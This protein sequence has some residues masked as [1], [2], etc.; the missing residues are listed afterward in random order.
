MPENVEIALSYSE[1][2]DS[3]PGAMPERNPGTIG[4]PCCCA[5]AQTASHA[6]NEFESRHDR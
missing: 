1:V 6:L 5:Q 3:L 4:L 2:P